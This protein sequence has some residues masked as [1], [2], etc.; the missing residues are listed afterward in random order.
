MALGAKR[1]CARLPIGLAAD[2]GCNDRHEHGEHRRR[3]G[4]ERRSAGRAVVRG[5]A[6][7]ADAPEVPRDG[8][9]PDRLTPQ[10]NVG[11]GTDHER[12]LALDAESRV[13]VPV[14]RRENHHLVDE[15]S[16]AFGGILSQL[17]PKGVQ[18]VVAQNRKAVRRGFPVRARVALEHEK[19]PARGTP[20]HIVNDLVADKHRWHHVASGDPRSDRTAPSMNVLPPPV[21][22]GRMA[23]YVPERRA[24][25]G[26]LPVLVGQRG[27]GAVGPPLGR[28]GKVRH[29][30][31]QRAHGALRSAAQEERQRVA[32]GEDR[33]G[34]VDALRDLRVDVPPLLFVRQQQAV[35]GGPP[36]DSGELPRQVLGI[37]DAHVHSLSAHRGVAMASVAGQVHTAA[38]EVLRQA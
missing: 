9:L 38:A 20:D 17:T 28:L 32:V 16:A 6:K 23:A 35:I 5:H 7:T 37:L 24:G 34:E 36:H 19:S 33:R 2:D 8:A 21:D 29:H 18:L 31:H 30:A 13:R 25:G 4:V 15:A 1:E 3:E 22:S 10:A 11:V 12:A 26:A 27:R 14:A